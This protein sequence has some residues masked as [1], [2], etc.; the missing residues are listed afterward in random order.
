[1]KVL[2]R[3]LPTRLLRLLPTPLLPLLPTPLL[4]LLPSPLLRLL[5]AL[6]LRRLLPPFPPPLPTPLLT[7][8][9]PLTTFQIAVQHSPYSLPRFWLFWRSIHSAS[10]HSF[11]RVWHAIGC[12][13]KNRR[14]PAK[15]RKS[16]R[17]S[18]RAGALSF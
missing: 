8:L 7:P 18:A 6:F 3:L 15:L 11:G 16:V 14:H 5:P 12:Q 9:L 1:M 10:Q 4:R 13:R 17:A 2:L